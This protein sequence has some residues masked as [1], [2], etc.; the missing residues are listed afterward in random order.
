VSESIWEEDGTHVEITPYLDR[1]RAWSDAERDAEAQ[2]IAREIR[3]TTRRLRALRRQQ[4]SLD[5]LRLGPGLMGDTIGG[6]GDD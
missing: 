3:T 4:S 2:A 6:A 5:L 1:Y